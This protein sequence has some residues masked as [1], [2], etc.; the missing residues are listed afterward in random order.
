[1]DS[2]TTASRIS[3][4][5][6]TNTVRQD[7]LPKWRA[8]RERADVALHDVRHARR[9]TVVIPAMNEE[10]NIAWVLRGLPA[11]VDEVILV[12]GES[13]D[14][15]VEVARSVRP[16]I[17]VI[18]QERPGKGAALRAGFEAARGEYIIMIDADGSMDPGE[19]ELYV[20]TL[21]AGHDMVKGSRFL[22]GGGTDDMELL[23]RLGNRALLAVGNV[24]YRRHFTDLCY[25]FM[26]F[27]A[28]ALPRLMLE[29]DGFEI[30]TEIVV[31]AI[32]ADL[33]ITE[34]PSF[35]LPR[36]YGESNLNTWR[37]GRRVL[38]RL[39]GERRRGLPRRPAAT[40]DR[41]GPVPLPSAMAGPV[42]VASA[43]AD[44]SDD[45]G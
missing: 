8:T 21:A 23:R 5:P 2:N 31:R 18:G 24:L 35:E 20:E 11:V 42:Q 13:I 44:G 9:V 33:R 6:A 4:P 3:A 17:T 32:K 37:D 7:P 39:L 29:S 10:R 14:A 25:G 41:R 40:F 16:D 43:A 12:D 30:E 27:R 19:I 38:A 45:V 26:G 15:T 1:M 36:R 34:V 28:S 22:D